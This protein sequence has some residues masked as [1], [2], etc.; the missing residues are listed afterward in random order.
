M[1]EQG[2]ERCK[3]HIL[4]EKNPHREELFLVK[5]E[6]IILEILLI[7]AL[8][9]IFIY[10]KNKT[11]N[12]SQKPVLDKTRSWPNQSNNNLTGN[13]NRRKNYG[14]YYSNKSVTSL[15]DKNEEIINA[16]LRD[17]KTIHFNYEDRNKVRTSRTVNPNRL[18]TYYFDDDGEMLCLEAFCN[19]RKANRTFALFRMSSVTII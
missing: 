11:E 8:V 6:E 2:S 12:K 7:I 14:K 5:N 19:L 9:L 17:K 3:L 1:T 10:F 16:A 4:L 18:F 15:I 13:H